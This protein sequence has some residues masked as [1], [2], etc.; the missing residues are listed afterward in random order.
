[1]SEAFKALRLPLIIDAGVLLALAVQWARIR[2]GSISSSG[3]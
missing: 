2:L 1:M 3:S